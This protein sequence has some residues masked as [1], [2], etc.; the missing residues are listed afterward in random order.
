MKRYLIYI[1]LIF[2]GGLIAYII[3]G[4]LL[5]NRL[6]NP[7]ENPYAYELNEYEEIDPSMIKYSEVK[8]IGLNIPDP[9][10]IASYKDRLGIAY[11]NHLQVI[12]TTGVELYRKSINAQVTCISYSHEGVIYLGCQDHVELFDENGNTIQ[13]WDTIS[14]NAIITSIA[15]NDNSV[16]VANAGNQEVLIY[17]FDGEIINSFDGK[18]RVESEF[19]FIIPSPYFDVAVDPDNELWV[20]NTGLHY[21]EN[22]TK[23][24]AL[25]A[26]W[27]ESSF[28]VEGFTGCCNPAHF[29]ILSNGAFVTSEKGVVRIKVYLPSGELDCVVAA[30]DKFEKDS[31]APDLTSD[32]FGRIYALDMTKKMIRVF[33]RNII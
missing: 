22:Y 21:V 24:G 32:P 19:G 5:S 28:T 33:E 10:G 18:S 20:A 30:P 16:F 23:N 13:K 14:H 11:K 27:G 6:K 29:T 3:I 2:L 7:N 17:N 8:R 15:V 31:E 25:R 9:K 4:D 12:D 26:Y 1:M